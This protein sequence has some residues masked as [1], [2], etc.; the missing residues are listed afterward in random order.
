MQNFCHQSVEPLRG[1]KSK[2]GCGRS[3]HTSAAARGRPGRPLPHSRSSG[4]ILS[5]QKDS[6]SLL[7]LAFQNGD[8]GNDDDDD[9]NGDDVWRSECQKQNT[10]DNDDKEGD[11]M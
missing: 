2:S 8:N 3:H 11:D 10:D 1:A 9:E 7:Y 4:L 5:L 6:L